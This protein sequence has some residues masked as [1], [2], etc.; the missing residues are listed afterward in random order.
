MRTSTTFHRKHPWVVYIKEVCSKDYK[1]QKKTKK[2]PRRIQP[3]QTKSPRRIQPNLITKNNFKGK[4]TF[5]NV[6]NKIEK[7][8]PNFYNKLN[9]LIEE[10][11]KKKKKKTK[12]N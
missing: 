7:R 4:K 6:V 5:M 11:N 3:V 1:K 12:K 9:Q 2:S 8:G 10:E